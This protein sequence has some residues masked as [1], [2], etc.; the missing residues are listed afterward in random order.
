MMLKQSILMLM[1]PSTSN[2]NKFPYN[3]KQQEGTK[4]NHVKYEKRVQE[5][6]L[7]QQSRHSHSL[8]QGFI[9]FQRIIFLPMGEIAN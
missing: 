8:I 1:F 3:N 6:T 5:F 4:K 2:N 7:Y 9:H